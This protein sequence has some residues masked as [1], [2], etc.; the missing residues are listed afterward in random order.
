MQSTPLISVVI[1][2]FNRRQA[3][4]LVLDGYEQQ[5]PTDLSFELVVVDDG[6]T[7]DSQELLASVRPER[8]RLRVLRQSNAGPAAA[9]N[10]ALP[11]VEGD[12]VLFTGDDIEPHT[13]LLAEHV[14]GHEQDSDSGKA[15]LGLTRWPEGVRLT[16]T[17]RHVD[18]VGAQ[19]FSYHYFVD[20]QEYDFRHFYTSNVSLRR[21]M[22]ELEPEGF[23]TDF[24]AAAF[25]DAEFAYRLSMH[26]LRIRYRAAAVAFHHHRYQVDGFF[27]RQRRCGEMAAQ[28][29]DKHPALKKWLGIA[30]LERQRMEILAAGGPSPMVAELARSLELWEGRVLG[31]AGWAEGVGGVSLDPLLHPLFEVGYVGG[32]ADAL[33]TAKDARTVRASEF[34][35]LVPPGVRLFASQASNDGVPLPSVDVAALSR[36][37][38]DT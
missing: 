31:L 1:P 30:P 13:R 21:R 23:C 18:G 37:D 38:S 25:E 33:F 8:Y 32:L 34:L 10:L 35:R 2:T 12:L 29:Y 6:S 3:L 17:M 11:E 15:I 27:G 19:Q 4:Q 9:R 26:G 22:L 20:G 28:L 5:Q 7:D 36:L 14:A 16:A 24:P